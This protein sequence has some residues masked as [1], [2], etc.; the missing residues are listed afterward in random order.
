VNGELYRRAC[1][2]QG[3]EGSGG[4]NVRAVALSPDATLVA[5]AGTDGTVLIWDRATCRELHKLTGHTGWVWDVAFGPKGGFL[6][7]AGADKTVRLWDVATG[8]LLLTVTGHTAELTGVD[9]SPDGSRL[10][11]SSWDQTVAVWDLDLALAAAQASG[12]RAAGLEA[13]AQAAGL[14]LFSLPTGGD[15]NDVAFSLDGTRLAVADQKGVVTVWKLE[16]SPPSAA[17]LLWTLS[18]NNWR[19]TRLVFSPDGAW[20]ATAG[21]DG[22][23]RVWD[24]TSGEELLVLSLGSSFLTGAAFS[25]DGALLATTGADRVT[26]LYALRLSDLAMLAQRRLNRSLTREECRRYL[27]L[28]QCPVR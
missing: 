16:P 20:L 6:V 24:L 18:A 21:G 25:P 8:R 10:A 23:A 15:A 12:A 1:T 5:T 9:I 19:I 11:T 22:A 13:P 7:T 27:H 26:Q 2:M 28:E 17:Q 3:H 4:G 14:L